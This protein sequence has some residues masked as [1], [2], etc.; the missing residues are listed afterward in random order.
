MQLSLVVEGCVRQLE[1][2]S[3]CKHKAA[4]ERVQLFV[5]VV[6]CC[7]SPTWYGDG[8]GGGGFSSKVT[9]QARYLQ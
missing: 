5:I 7:Y 9:T 1:F 4:T 3:T 8:I 2:I 6:W